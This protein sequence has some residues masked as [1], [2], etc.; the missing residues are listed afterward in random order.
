VIREKGVGERKGEESS[1]N[2]LNSRA[3]PFKN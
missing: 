1:V 2:R 3:K